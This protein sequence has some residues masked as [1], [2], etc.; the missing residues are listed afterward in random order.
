MLTKIQ[1]MLLDLVSA[2]NDP[3]DLQRRLHR[4]LPAE[5]RQA[6][7]VLNVIA[8]DWNLVAKE[9]NGAIKSYGELLEQ[10]SGKRPDD[11]CTLLRLRLPGGAHDSPVSEEKLQEFLQN[12]IESE[13]SL[14][15]IFA[16]GRSRLT[17][18]FVGRQL[19]SWMAGEMYRLQLMEESRCQ[20]LRLALALERFH[21]EKGQYPESLEELGL[22]PMSSDMYLRYEKTGTGYRIQNAVFRLEQ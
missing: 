12:Y 21:R 15:F 6:V 2:T 16:S 17:G 14:D 9:L 3:S 22:K 20:A 11:Q 1:F 10:A 7:E 5:M 13:Q 8:F 4:T 19:V 18:A